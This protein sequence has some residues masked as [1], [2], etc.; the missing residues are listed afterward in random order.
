MLAYGVALPL[1]I[2]L[3][4]A[5]AAADLFVLAWL[6]TL[7]HAQLEFV[8]EPDAAFRERVSVV[9]PMYNEEAN[10]DAI[11][12]AMRA[13]THTNLE[14][15]AV[16]DRSTD[17][18]AAKLAEWQ[19]RWPELKVVT[20]AEHPPDWKGKSW[21]MYH[22]ARVATGEWLAFIDAD[23]KVAPESVAGAAGTCSRR[24]WDALGVLGRIR[25]STF[26]E[27]VTHVNLSTHYLILASES[28]QAMMCG[29]YMVVRRSVY[30]AVGGW[31]MVYDEM[32]DDVALPRLLSERGYVPRLRVWLGSHEVPPYA[33]LP[34]LWRA[35]RRV[36]A[37]GTGFSPLDAGLPA[38]LGITLHLGPW[39]LLVWALLHRW[40]ATP[41]AAVTLALTVATI[42][43]PL[44]SYRRLAGI[45]GVGAWICLTRPLG[46]TLGTLIH[47]DAA[48]RA[49][50]GGLRWKG[51]EFGRQRGFPERPQEIES[52]AGFF[53]AARERGA[54]RAWLERMALEREQVR[55][56]FDALDR[57]PLS[58]RF[59]WRFQPGT[60][61]WHV[62][63]VSLQ[64]GAEIRQRLEAQ[65]ITPSSAR[66][67]F[68][69]SYG[70]WLSQVAVWLPGWLRGAGRRYGVLQDYRALGAEEERALRGEA[71]CRL[72]QQYRP[73]FQAT[74]PERAGMRA[75]PT[76]CS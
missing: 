43:L 33:D 26:L 41:L 5:L 64:H 24:G 13:Q 63:R 56:M 17:G 39:A 55:Y 47:L 46:D 6:W 59:I 62:V 34:E 8:P 27:C 3:A 28:Q 22:G 16:N 23:L 25:Y 18:T 50:F 29:Q 67:F 37:G 52:V 54:T 2:F 20:L 45:L 40:W 57:W 69:T 12:G 36:I 61:V 66:F 14:V 31:A 53:V 75:Q 1:M 38:L 73:W 65:G 51:Q 76:S 9:I 21:P 4:I 48:L 49:A 11:L 30:E 71:F 44:L 72:E 10:V 68:L 60:T 74:P 15:I 58:A 7:H 32:Q 19:R 70:A 42:V 35:M